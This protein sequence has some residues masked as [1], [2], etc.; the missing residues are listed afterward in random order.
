VE[1]LMEVLQDAW[2]Q[3]K[4]KIHQCYKPFRYTAF[5]NRLNPTFLIVTG[6]CRQEKN[7]PEVINEQTEIHCNMHQF[8]SYFC[9][10]RTF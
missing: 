10:H 4:K 1:G 3:N 6:T 2:L 9:S 7:M 8:S 5:L